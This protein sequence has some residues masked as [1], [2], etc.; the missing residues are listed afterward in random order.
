MHL[1]IPINLRH[2][3]ENHYLRIT[4]DQKMNVPFLWL[5]C[6]PLKVN[7]SPRICIILKD[8]SY[9]T[10][11]NINSG[12]WRTSSLISGGSLKWRWHFSSICPTRSCNCTTEDGH[13]SFHFPWILFVLQLTSEKHIDEEHFCSN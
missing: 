10:I 2:A 3:C 9:K 13:Y 12:S 8:L 7:F 6:A 4:N 11:L 5:L 1:L